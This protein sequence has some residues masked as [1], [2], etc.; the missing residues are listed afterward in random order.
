MVEQGRV[1]QGGL[2][3][4]SRGDHAN[5]VPRPELGLLYPRRG[6]RAALAV[7]DRIET[8]VVLERVG[9]DQEVV[10]TVLR[11]EDDPAARVL[12]ARDWP[13]ADGDV[14]VCKLLVLEHGDRPRL[15]RGGRSE[16]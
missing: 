4:G 5:R 2:N 8:E 15:G 6:D 12:F 14:D 3:S 1:V 13:E 7:H 11:P 10:P 16:E 9:P